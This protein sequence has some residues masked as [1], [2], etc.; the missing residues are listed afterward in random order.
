[1]VPAFFDEV[2]LTRLRIG[3][4]MITH[5]FLMEIG[6]MPYLKDCLVPLSVLHI[7]AECLTYDEERRRYSPNIVKL[8]VTVIG[9]V[10]TLFLPP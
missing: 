5:S 2:V 6:N 9:G 4:T 7:L 8:L 3:Y 10:F 1:M